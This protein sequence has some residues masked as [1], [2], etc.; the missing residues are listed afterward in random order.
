MKSFLLLVL[1]FAVSFRM[2]VSQ[3]NEATSFKAGAAKI[4]ITPKSEDLP[5][6]LKGIHDHLYVRAVVLD[7]GITQAA[8]I[9]VDA[10]I[11]ESSWLKY[12]QNLE[13]ELGIP[14]PNIFISPSHSH[15]AIFIRGGPGGQGN[16]PKIALFA[17][18]L[19]K[20]MIEVVKQA[21]ANLQPAKI[22]FGTGTCH[23]NI[24]RD[25]IDPVTRLWSQ[26]PNYEGISDKTVAVIKF[27]TLA[28]E[29]LAVYYN[30]A[31]HPNTMFMS[32][33]ISADFPG[34]T[35]SY[36]EEYYHD[37]VVVLWSM[38]A[39][40]DQNPIS[41]K[42]M[43]DVGRFKTEAALASGKAKDESEAIMMGSSMDVQVDPKLLARQAQM[44]SSLGQILGE[45][46]LRVMDL[47]K[48]MDTKIRIYGSQDMVGCPG[49]TR[50][51]TG[52]E[53]SPGTY[54]DGDS[55]K[56]RLSLLMLGDIA[57]TGVNAEVY[58]LIAQRLKNE[59][60]FSNTIM[61]T[62]TNGS[63]NSGYIPSDDAF[64]RYTFQVLSSRLKP[65][66]AE[67]AIV[68]GLLDM[69]DKVN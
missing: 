34:V 26:G 49:R 53:G 23:L 9:S 7:N 24:N 64:V 40:G 37:K 27:E 69:M 20:A 41:I 62:T 68:N 57:L 30:Y 28:G 58:N 39:A 33:V 11:Q 52:R 31:M 61:A 3:A 65:G 45:E 32:G 54:V 8:L 50:T 5:S 21:K 42:P 44:I 1:L 29:P 43:M 55:V 17:S 51:N 48:R 56:I 60:S 35:S 67:G 66:C 16:D 13:K 6:N 12:T 14:V 22:G 46:I 38:G 63:A 2:A 19:D 36:I 59:S 4:D 18:N 10:G 15:S 47:T 25:V